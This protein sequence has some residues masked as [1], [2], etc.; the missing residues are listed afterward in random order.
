MLMMM[1]M[2]MMMMCCQIYEAQSLQSPVLS[3]SKVTASTSMQSV[4]EVAE[5]FLAT[6][7]P[8]HDIWT[9]YLL[10]AKV[11]RLLCLCGRNIIIVAI[12]QSY[13]TLKNT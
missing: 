4:S 12:N 1:M 7:L 6:L 5:M 13:F 11:I 10:A 9:C 2:M 3:V 8:P